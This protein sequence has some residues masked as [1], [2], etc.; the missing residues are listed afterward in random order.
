MNRR[1]RLGGVEG[2]GATSNAHHRAAARD[3]TVSLSLRLRQ[4]SSRESRSSLII[5]TN[6]S[7]E[8]LEKVP[9]AADRPAH[10]GDDMKQLNESLAEIVIARGGPSGSR[11][12]SSSDDPALGRAAPAVGSADAPC[13]AV[14]RCVLGTARAREGPDK[15]V[16]R[17]P[18]MSAR[19][20][21]PRS[22][23]PARATRHARRSLTGPQVSCVE[24]LRQTA[25]RPAKRLHTA[26][27][28]DQ[29]F[30]HGR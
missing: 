7:A 20:V 2:A 15:A 24:L 10:I 17:G 26:A 12:P 30:G 16:T 11:V 14:T 23:L 6:E 1:Q 18:D 29:A 27:L 19:V 3:A 13:M 22:G 5:R 8:H 9:T 28:G 25:C 4:P 21:L